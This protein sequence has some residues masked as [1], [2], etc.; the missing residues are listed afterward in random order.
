M[1][2]FGKKCWGIPIILNHH[3]SYVRE[4]KRE[5][6][7]ANTSNQYTKLN[8]LLLYGYLEET[9]LETLRTTVK[10]DMFSKFVNIE[11][12][13]ITKLSHL[14]IFQGNPAWIFAK[15]NGLVRS[16]APGEVIIHFWIIV[17]TVGRSRSCYTICMYKQ[18]RIIDI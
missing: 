4:C 10:S 18:R 13:N 12:L 6:S 14:S 5:Y 17:L 8:V 2:Y 16:R 15:D 9:A 11:N 7:K 3:F 1:E